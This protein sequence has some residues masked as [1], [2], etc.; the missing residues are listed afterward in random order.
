MRS[1]TSS[2]VATAT[3]GGSPAIAHEVADGP[4]G[5]V[6]GPSLDVV[7]PVFNE[8]ACLGELVRRV[9]VVRDRLGEAGVSLRMILVDDGSLD[10]SAIVMGELAAGRH[11]LEAIHLSRNFGHQAAVTAGIDASTGTYCA[12]LDADLQDPPELLPEMLERMTASG[13]DVVYGVRQE[14]LG[15]SGF[16]LRTAQLFYR[17]MRRGSGL[18]IP[19]DAG[20][21]RIMSKRV[22]GELGKLPEHHR[23][24]RAMVPWL[25]HRSCGFDYTREERFAGSTK[26]PIRKMLMLASHAVFSFSTLPIRIVQALGLALSVAGGLGTVGLTVALPFGVEPPLAVWILGALTLQTGII[27]LA[28]GLI[29]GYVFRIQDEVK[30]RP[31]Y[32]R[33]DPTFSPTFPPTAAPAIEEIR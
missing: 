32:V 3:A 14:R 8:E 25:G 6:P 23:L 28:I 19:L 5:H 18:D 30:G 15:E 24:L 16:K 31:A 2:V 20:D 17:L 22:V 33:V 12:I 9:S 10:R 7:V 29:G 27:V 4:A 11:W 1:T 21:F 26:Y 13:S